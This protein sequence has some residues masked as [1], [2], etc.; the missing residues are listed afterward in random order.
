MDNAQL[1]ILCLDLLREDLEVPRVAL[2]PNY[3]AI[4]LVG[5]KI[6]PTKVELFYIVFSAFGALEWH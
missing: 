6:W 4:K 2:V 1:F 5:V 3:A